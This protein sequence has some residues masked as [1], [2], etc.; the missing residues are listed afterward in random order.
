[1][2]NV[3]MMSLT[4]IGT[5][6]SGPRFG[7][8]SSARAC[9]SANSGSKFTHALT[10]PLRS[11]IRATQSRVTASHVASPRA[12][13]C[14][15]SAAPSW[16]SEPETLA[17]IS[18]LTGT[19]G[20]GAG[21][22][23]EHRA[24]HQAGAAR[25]VEVEQAADQFARGIE[26]ADRLVVG[27]EH[28]AVG[29]DAQAAEGEG[30]AASHGVAFIGRRVE[31][32]GPIALV[33]GEPLGAAAVLDV[34]IEWH[35][36]L[37]RGVPFLDGL[38]ELGGVDAFELLRELLD[39]ARRHLGDLADLVFV[40]LQVLHLL[41]KDL[42]GELA[43]LLQHHAAILGISVIAEIG[44]LVDEALA[45]GV[46]QDAERIGVFL[47][48]I[49]DGEIAELRRVHFPL[50]G[51]TARPVA[52]RCGADVDRHA[53][54][55]AGVEARATH[56][57]EIPARAEI[58]RAP[59]RIGLKTAA[60]EHHRFRPQLAHLAVLAHANALDPVAVEQQIEAARGIVDVDAALF[61]RSCQH[62]DQAGARS[63]G[64][65]RQPA[66]E[67]ELAVDLEGL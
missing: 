12:I 2:S 4:P 23:A 60:G 61:C 25:I 63:E 41:V 35:V 26:A 11:A 54:A 5:P 7:E 43:R 56:L 36:G 17:S 8:R 47:E 34:R 46:D 37:H 1:M 53:D 27:I 59:F 44:A 38:D 16:L 6:Y 10:T 48:L 66:P 39:G 58:A 24:G 64:F 21:D 51:M 62:G 28:F 22:L 14:T 19:A 30:N 31:G 49:A 57:G 45:G 65:H 33:D 18:V 29:I 9:A 67:F 15:I 42:P 13:F 52:A 50:H 55:L 32:V 40:A 20:R 3:S